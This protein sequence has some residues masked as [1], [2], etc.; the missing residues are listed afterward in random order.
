MTMYGA[1]VAA[2]RQMAQVFAQAA[3]RLDQSRAT[4]HQTVAVTAWAGADRQEF[5]DTWNG[6]DAVALDRCVKD[7]ADAARALLAN[8]EAQE[9]VSSDLDAAPGAVNGNV[10]PVFA[11]LAGRAMPPAVEGFLKDLDAGM[12]P[13]DINAAWSALSSDERDWL[14]VNRP[15]RIGNLD[16]IP[17]A[18]RDVANRNELNR[19]WGKL[20]S[21]WD[22]AR[23]QWPNEPAEAL[24]WWVWKEAG[25]SEEE[26]RSVENLH[27]QLGTGKNGDFGRLGAD[28][29]LIAFDMK[30]ATAT[31][32][33]VAVGDLD[34]ASTVGVFVPGIGTRIG[35]GENLNTTLENM[36]ALRKETGQILEDH[37]GGV[38]DVAQV[39]WLGYSAPA[40]LE[41]GPSVVTAIDATRAIDGGNSL[42][43]FGDGLEAVNPD[44]RK[45]VQGHSY[46]S[47]TST[48]GLAETTAF[49]SFVAFG[50]PGLPGPAPLGEHNP[51]DALD[52][53]VPADERYFGYAFKD[54]IAW[55]R[56]HGPT[57]GDW[58]FERLP[59]RKVDGYDNST[60]HSEYLD[61]GT[62]FQRSLAAI[63]A[64]H[65]EAIPR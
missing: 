2:M 43:S 53:N 24:Q 39:F 12:S 8:A 45:T 50:S 47:V 31:R 7:L 16:G 52:I 29:H 6:R 19:Q 23:E 41:G 10:Q 4:I 25:L 44:A 14:L 62:S 49:D 40:G 57:P 60:G 5:H 15:F 58:G 26:A 13:Q 55:S 51:A 65:S 11:P 1:D 54:G 42:A 27:A 34:T 59:T 35:K 63:T 48:Y 61:P 21:A 46:G 3:D 22:Q 64:G 37:G 17:Y 28:G 36:V 56:S 32:A 30:H 9:L 18:D 38:D 33:A 20:Q